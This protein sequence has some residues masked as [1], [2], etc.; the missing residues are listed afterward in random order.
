[1]SELERK[2]KSLI[3]ITGL[4]IVVNIL[5]IWFIWQQPIKLALVLFILSLVELWNIRSKKVI[6]I[7]IIS[8]LGGIF[9]E[10]GAIHF[11][12][13]KYSLPNFLNIPLW[14][15]PAW[16]NAGIIIVSFYKLFSKIS[17]LRKEQ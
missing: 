4:F 3:V 12:N 13:W 1:M 2:E 5:S 11:G 15:I 6:F 10:I 14:L 17:F 8:A 16:G 9:V 7:F